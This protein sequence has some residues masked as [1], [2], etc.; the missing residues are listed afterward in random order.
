MADVIIPGKM[1]MVKQL[2]QIPNS[3][4]S[5]CIGNRIQ[6]ALV[7]QRQLQITIGHRNDE[8]NAR[9][10]VHRRHAAWPCNQHENQIETT[11]ARCRNGFLEVDGWLRFRAIA[12][13]QCDA[14]YHCGGSVTRFWNDLENEQSSWNRF[15]LTSLKPT[16]HIRLFSD[17][18]VRGKIP[19]SSTVFH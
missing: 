16:N 19:L 13:R 6:Y 10:F 5:T 3:F 8:R 11:V 17:D 1:L 2:S 14:T 7:E 12:V 9:R 18:R 15:Y 4:F